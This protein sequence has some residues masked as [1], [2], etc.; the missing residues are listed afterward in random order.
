ML[1]QMRERRLEV[2]TLISSQVAGVAI[3]LE[4]VHVEVAGRSGQMTQPREFV[5]EMPSDI[6]GHDMLAVS[7]NRPRATN[8]DPQLVQELGVDVVDRALPV[9]GDGRRKVLEHRPKPFDGRHVRIEGHTRRALA[10]AGVDVGRR[11]HLLDERAGDL[12]EAKLLQ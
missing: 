9:V 12:H 1:P 4:D 6:C 2:H 10:T 8:G 7:E 11:D 5:E 3:P